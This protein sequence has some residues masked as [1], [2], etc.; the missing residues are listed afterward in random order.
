LPLETLEQ[1]ETIS[2]AFLAL[3]EYLTPQERAVFLLRDIFDY[4]YAEIASMLGLSTANCR[5]LLHRARERLAEKRQRFEPSPEQQRQLTERFLAAT[6]DGD[7]AALTDLLAA[8]VVVHGDGGGKVPAIARP[9][10][11]REPVMKFLIGIARKALA[12]V[13]ITM[14]E[15]NGGQAM[16]IWM[17]AQL[18]AVFALEF[19]GDRISRFYNVLN[20]DKLAYIA[21]QLG[22]V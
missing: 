7:L 16:L 12:G 2:L 5:Q 18:Y 9:L 17:E 15:V 1:R 4:D 22:T 13:T 6:Q 20:P 3:L 14:A 19:D 11:G 10:A 8:D 21:R